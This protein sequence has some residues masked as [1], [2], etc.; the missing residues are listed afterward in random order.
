MRGFYEDVTTLHR[1]LTALYM[2]VGPHFSIFVGGLIHRLI[3]DGI[4]YRSTLLIS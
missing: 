1:F 2:S 4:F 3:Y